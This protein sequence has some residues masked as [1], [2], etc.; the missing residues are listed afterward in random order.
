VKTENEDS[1]VEAINRAEEIAD[2][3]GAEEEKPRLLV[4][5]CN[6][7]KTVS[8]LRNILSD[9]GGLYDRGVPV[10]LVFDQMQKGMVAQVTKPDLLVLRTH[11][12][13]RPYALKETKNGLIEVNTALPRQFAVMY[14][15]WRGE[16]RLRPLNGIASAPLLH[17][18]GAIS[19]NEGYDP[20][21]G[22]WCENVPD[23]R[24][25]IPERPTK[26]AATAALR[27]IRETFKTF[28]FADAITTDDGS[29][30]AV[31]D[32]SLPP[33]R[34]ESAFLVAL[35][36]AVCRPVFIWRRACWSVQPRCPAP[37]RARGS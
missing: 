2:P 20:S 18:D 27:L 37:A 4:E 23:L 16:W 1:I 25:L 32:T 5:K 33:G 3:V 14:L 8:A 6:P 7:D 34:D 17:N 22:M 13:A 24:G 10:R 11:Q 29:G 26:E 28:C 30:V 9:R 15:D 12:V 31:V 35:M 36:T 21:S 19:C